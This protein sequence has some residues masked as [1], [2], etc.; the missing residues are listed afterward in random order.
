MI[1]YQIIKI[2]FS[3]KIFQYFWE[4]Y[5]R[6]NMKKKMELSYIKNIL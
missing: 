6:K 1:I 2:N 4:I 3:K 5:S